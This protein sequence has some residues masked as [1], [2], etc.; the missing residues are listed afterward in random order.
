MFNDNYTLKPLLKKRRRYISKPEKQPLNMIIARELKRTNISEYLIYMFQVEDLIR[1]SQCDVSKVEENLSSKFNQP[2]K[3]MAEIK[4][5][6]EALCRMMAEEGLQQSG[7]LQF[8]SNQIKELTDFHYRLLEFT[9]DENYPKLY[10]LAKEDIAEF[11]KKIPSNPESE[12][13]VCLYALYTLMLLRLK[14]MTI[15]I[16]TLEAMTNFTKWMAYLSQ[17]FHEF[18]KGEFEF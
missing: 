3:Q 8:I 7:H 1:L 11:R 4:K 10:S 15:T 13:E 5:W 18:E 16:E 2:E 12:I 9:D 14:K 17:K 6:Y